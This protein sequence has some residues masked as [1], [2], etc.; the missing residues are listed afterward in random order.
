MAFFI[1]DRS[2][3]LSVSPSTE[4]WK[5]SFL[6]RQY[7]YKTIATMATT[8]T[9]KITTMAINAPVEMDFFDAC[10][11][12]GVTEIKRIK[13]TKVNFGEGAN[14]CCRMA[15]IARKLNVVCNVVNA[16]CYFCSPSSTLR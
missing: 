16:Q 10:G 3:G 14:K 12:A 13:T 6:V 2:E 5:D 1:L 7:L 4:N 8:I 15:C 9:T 11:G